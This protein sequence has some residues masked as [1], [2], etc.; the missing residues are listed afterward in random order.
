ASRWVVAG[1]G[2]AVGAGYYAGALLTTALVVVSLFWLNRIEMRFVKSR[3]G[4]VGVR[5]IDRHGQL[6]AVSAVLG[7]HGVNIRGV[8]IEREVGVAELTFLMNNMSPSTAPK[9]LG[10]LLVLDVVAPVEWHERR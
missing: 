4:K 1:I 7:Q 3:H 10:E 8:E 9:L 5:I 6:A 2:L